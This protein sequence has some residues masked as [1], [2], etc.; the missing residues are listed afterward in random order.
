[1]DNSLVVHLEGT[2]EE[3]LLGYV[4]TRPDQNRSEL[5][6]IGSAFVYMELFGTGPGVYT[7]PF[8]NPSGTDPTLDLQ[9]SGSSFGSVPGPVPKRSRVN[10]RPIRSDFRTGSI[11]NWSR[12]CK[13][14]LGHA[15]ECALLLFTRPVHKKSTQ[16]AMHSF[17]KNKKASTYFHT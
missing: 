15:C 5:N 7:G 16:Y 9:N 11:W 6:R 4:Y 12:T 13:H 17:S 14:S 1:M 3:L 2:N 10:R 8:W